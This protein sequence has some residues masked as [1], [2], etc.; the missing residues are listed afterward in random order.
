MPPQPAETPPPITDTP[1]SQPVITI[2]QPA[3]TPLPA[4]FTTSSFSQKLTSGGWEL[5]VFT[6]VISLVLPP[7]GLVVAAYL[8]YRATKTSLKKL[9]WLAIIS[10]MAALAGFAILSYIFTFSYSQPQR[11]RYSTLDSF[12][13]NVQ[14]SQTAMYF[15]KPVE[16]TKSSAIRDKTSSSVALAHKN[17]DGFGVSYISATL[18]NTKIAN[19]KTY[20]SNLDKQM[21]IGNGKDYQYLISPIHD[22]IKGATSHGL[23][24]SLSK[25]YSFTNPNIAA[26]S[27][28]FDVVATDIPNDGQRLAPMKGKVIMIVGQRSIDYF[29]AF[30]L[31]YNWQPNQ[32]IWNQIFG[33]LKLSE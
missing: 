20:L 8:F 13:F 32:A 31:G 5:W 26:K 25:P 4:E 9:Y 33:S 16:I 21:K 15:K 11:Y 1:A 18:I 22:F 29:G 7:V 17:K 3:I 28:Q 24:I 12:N 14:A 6:L 30:S 2:S 10:F 23:A 27:W 19:D